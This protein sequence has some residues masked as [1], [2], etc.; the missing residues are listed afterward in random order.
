M[1]NL[2]YI[3]NT[4]LPVENINDVST[5]IKEYYNIEL[6]DQMD[7]LIPEHTDE[8]YDEL[9]NDIEDKSSMMDDMEDEIFQLN[10][11]IDELEARL[12]ETNDKI[13]ELEI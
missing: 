13:F 2:I 3:N 9:I 5:I 10:N 12:D 6:A 7:Q 4:W 1:T 8:E 11:K